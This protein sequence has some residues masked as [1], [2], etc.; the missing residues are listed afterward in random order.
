MKKMIT[1][2]LVLGLIAFTS[3]VNAAVPTVEA[4]DGATGTVVTTLIWNNIQVKMY[5]SNFRTY[6][7]GTLCDINCEVTTDYPVDVTVEIRSYY[8]HP[9]YENVISGIA[10]H[11]PVGGTGGGFSQSDVTP[12]DYWLGVSF[13]G[14]S[15]TYDYGFE[16]GY[17]DE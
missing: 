12:Y 6:S 10:C 17:Y 11:I 8:Y 5:Q 2:L 14:S 7:D 4:E 15:Q 13:L 9:A 16:Y 1:A 3:N